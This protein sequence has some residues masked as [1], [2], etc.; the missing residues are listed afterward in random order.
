MSSKNKTDHQNKKI[1]QMHHQIIEPEEKGYQE[2]LE[3]PTPEWICTILCST[4]LLRP[5]FL[6]SLK[7]IVERNSVFSKQRKTQRKKN[8]SGRK[9]KRPVGNFEGPSEFRQMITDTKMFC[10]DNSSTDFKSPTGLL[11]WGQ[12]REREE[13]SSQWSGFGVH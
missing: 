7:I 10:E 2:F 6:G 4:K 12:D 8:E 5:L 3:S 11:W 9:E 1:E 13:C